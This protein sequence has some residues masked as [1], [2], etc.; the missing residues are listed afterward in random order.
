MGKRE[1]ASFFRAFLTNPRQVGAVM[2]SGKALASAMVEGLDER[3]TG[4][5]TVV[6]FGPGTGA[7]TSALLR[8]KPGDSAYLGIELDRHFVKTLQ[9]RFPTSRFPGANIVHGS[10]EHACELI[11]QL[12]LPEVGLIVCGLPFASLPKPVRAAIVGNV[13]RLLAT[14]EGGSFRTFQYV[15]ASKMRSARLFRQHMDQ[16]FGVGRRSKPVVGN[17]PPAYVL[18]WTRSAEPV[19]V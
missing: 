4:G 14:G 3:L 15:H 9:R 1:T 6:E 5:K 13:D 8:A 2:P 12:D 19:A 7:F 10:A 17:V 18:E 11:E 16:H